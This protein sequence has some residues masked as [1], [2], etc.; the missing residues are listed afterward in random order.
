MKNRANLTA[1]MLWT[2]A[3]LMGV[4]TSPTFADVI[5]VPDDISKIQ[6]AIIAAQNGDTIVISP[7]TYTGLANRDIGFL[8]KAITVRSQDPND[9]AVVMATIIDAGGSDGDEHRGFI[10]DSGEDANSILDGVTIINGYSASG[11]GG[12]RCINSSSPTIRNCVIRDNISNGDGGGIYLETSTSQV[13][14]CQIYGNMT[15][16]GNGG[17]I[18]CLDGDNLIT[19]CLIHDNFADGGQS[20]GGGI[21]C[22]NNTLDV[23]QS[24]IYGNRSVFGGGI[25]CF[26]SS[27][28]DI[29]QSSI[30][31]NSAEGSGGGIYNQNSTIEI[32][33]CSLSENR[34]F[35]G[36]GGGLRGFSQG[37]T[38]LANSILW[39]NRAALPGN[40]TGN[41]ISLTPTNGE[42]I[43]LTIGYCNIQGGLNN[44]VN[45]MGDGD[46]LLDWQVGNIDI[47]PLFVKQ[48]SIDDS[49]SL[50]DLDDD[51][52][53]EGDYHLQEA[54]LCIDRGDPNSDFED[55]P[56]PNGDRVN[57]GA[58]GNTSEAAMSI[59][60]P[61]SLTKGTVKG[62]KKRLEPNQPLLDSIV[63]K[64][65]LYENLE[66]AD[67]EDFLGADTV[68][69]RIDL[70]GSDDLPTT[71]ILLDTFDI[72]YDPNKIAVKQKFNY[73]RPK[74][75]NGAIKKFKLNYK[76]NI[77][78][79][80][81]KKV[82]LTGLSF[83]FK[84]EI[85]YGDYLG[86]IVIHS[87][88]ELASR[89]KI[90][91]C[92]LLG[93]SDELEI[94]K[95]KV[96]TKTTGDTLTAK[97]FVT[98]ELAH[99]DPPTENLDLT[100]E[101]VTIRWGG[102]DLETLV[103]DSFEELSPGRFRYPK[104]KTDPVGIIRKLELDFNK[105]R[106]TLTVKEAAPLASQGIIPLEFFT[107]S[108]NFDAL[109]N[110]ELTP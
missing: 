71:N 85:A 56:L 51:V 92:L 38:S 66:D 47:D 77:F 67:I 5:N 108:G 1:R 91:L 45:D 17:G 23:R 9:P 68:T 101:E 100:L 109:S 41:E 89:K 94:T 103:V 11:G 34:A 31:G 69:I 6:S 12:I 104:R 83:P 73:K 98:T 65:L 58:F 25:F 55:E 63:L 8:N 99:L 72:E 15:L 59:R 74:E 39:A 93:V 76:K 88:E 7:G 78:I 27:I 35:N 48:G 32:E 61:I 21:F 75:N 60:V 29:D 22:D 18:S 57:L 14:N 84:L 30:S 16:D 50:N 28:L 37:E 64:G 2:I 13:I 107:T 3:L 96:K 82:D 40:G 80:D 97:G 33:H 87:I 44:V 106:F 20:Q 62:D 90:P 54:S 79:L 110:I 81:A 53:N 102:N 36:L 19:N 10:F 46:V 26:D 4:A 70:V 43:E 95:A 24:Q 105:C 52:W 49:N 42:E 86:D